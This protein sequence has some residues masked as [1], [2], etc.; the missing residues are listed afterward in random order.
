VPWQVAENV[1]DLVFGPLTDYD[2]EALM[3]KMTQDLTFRYQID[4]EPIDQGQAPDWPQREL[5]DRLATLM[6]W[7]FDALRN[8]NEVEGA[9]ILGT[10]FTAA[11][12]ILPKLAA[13]CG[14][15]ATPEPWTNDLETPHFFWLDPKGKH[16]LPVAYDSGSPHGYLRWPVYETNG[17]LA[18][19]A[20]F[21]LPDFF[22]QIY[23]ASGD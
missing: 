11:R 2:E 18:W 19:W 13:A 16:L 4:Q 8:N 1:A 9:L 5:T 12:P 22:E 6:I 21:S 17:E 15:L 14:W 23:L 3:A 20:L 10:N 7:T